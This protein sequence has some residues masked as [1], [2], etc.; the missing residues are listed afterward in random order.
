MMMMVITMHEPKGVGN[1][2]SIMYTIIL[3]SHEVLRSFKQIM[4]EE[5]FCAWYNAVSM[6][7]ACNCYVNA[8]V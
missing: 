4:Y 2:Q 7:R 8:C 1:L 6:Y 3:S 5:L